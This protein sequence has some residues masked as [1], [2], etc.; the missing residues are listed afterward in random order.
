MDGFKRRRITAWLL[1][2]AGVGAI[3]L[4]LA[5]LLAR[6]Y[7]FRPTFHM[8]T[9][10]PSQDELFIIPDSEEEKIKTIMLGPPD[11][12]IH[13]PHNHR[14]GHELNDNPIARSTDAKRQVG[15]ELNPPLPNEKVF[16]RSQPDNGISGEL[17]V[18]EGK[19]LLNST[20]IK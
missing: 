18:G 17:K 5:L 19:E 6:Y 9:L 10:P 15:F 16:G 4:L 20:E 2:S 7:L 1:T 8:V 3:L 14:Q 11:E 12:I 13:S